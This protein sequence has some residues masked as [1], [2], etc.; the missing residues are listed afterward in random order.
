MTKIK[1][2][3]L[4]I[5]ASVLF[6]TFF[7]SSVHAADFHS[8]TS[9]AAM[10]GF[11][12]CFS[13]GAYK[14]TFKASEGASAF[15][16]NKLGGEM[17]KLPY[18]KTDAE[19]NN[20][21]CKQIVLGFGNKN[22]TL[23]RGLIP[24]S[25][26]NSTDKKTI[27][28][29]FAGSDNA[30]GS[31]TMG[32]TAEGS[33][34][35]D[36]GQKTSQLVV[37]FKDFDCRDSSGNT[38]SKKFKNMANNEEYSKLIFPT[39]TKDKNGHWFFG[40]AAANNSGIN[41]PEPGSG[42]AYNFAFCGDS[43]VVVHD[44]TV[45]KDILY[46]I[47]IF[48]NPDGFQNEEGSAQADG[49]DGWWLYNSNFLKGTIKEGTVQGS[50]EFDDWTLKYSGVGY[51]KGPL[52][53]LNSKNNA[54]VKVSKTEKYDDLAL[55]D[56]EVYDLYTYYVKDVY[57]KPVVC[58]GASNF[59]DYADKPQINWVD[60]KDCRID[61]DKQT[62]PPAYDVYGVDDKNHF[63]AKITLDDIIAKLATLDLS[64]LNTEDPGTAG[65]EPTD[66][67]N[68]DPDCHTK[69]GALGWIL[70]PI[71]DISSNMVEQV[72][73][74]M[75]QPYLS[76]DAALFDT[77]EKG[78]QTV[79]EVWGL[80]QGF[81]NLT[82]VIL[83]L[84]VIFSQLTGVG[85]DNYGIKKILPK[86]IIGA[87]LINMS[88][89]I[90]Q[91][92]VDLSNIL[93]RAIASMFQGVA[94][95]I[96]SDLAEKTVNL[97][98]GH[99]GSVSG[100]FSGVG[101]DHGAGTILLVIV[102]IAGVFGVG[103]FLAAGPA[104]IIP[105]L[106]ALISLV[107][108]IFFLFAL[109]ALRQ[110]IAVILVVVSP[111]AFAMY[112]LPNTK[113]IFDKW[114]QAF[115]GMLIAYPIA[116]ALVFGG[117]LVSKILLVA[118][119]SSEITSLG[120]LL[121]AAVV[122][123]AP[124]FFIPSV[125][126]KSM[127]AISGLGNIASRMQTTAKGKL[128]TPA[129]SYLNRS[130][131]NDYKLRRQEAREAG[132]SDRR[133]RKKGQIAR[134][135]LARLDGRDPDKMS[136]RQRVQ[137]RQAVRDEAAYAK[138]EADL[139]SSYITSLGNDDLSARMAAGLEEG[140]MEKFGSAMDELGGRD[141][142]ALLAQLTTLSE[143]DAWKNM[144]ERKKAAVAAKLRGQKGN[145]FAQA[146]GKLIAQ[147]QA[148]NVSSFNTLAEKGRIQD[149][150][151]EN[152]AT[153]LAS[154]DKDVYKWLNGDPSYKNA[155]GTDTKALARDSFRSD[156]LAEA[157]GQVS[158]AQQAQFAQFIAT[159]G[160]QATDAKAVSDAQLANGGNA[161]I[162][163]AYAGADSDQIK[164]AVDTGQVND[165]TLKGNIQ[166][167]F[168]DQIENINANNE[169]AG[170]TNKGLADAAGIKAGPQQVVIAGIK[171]GFSGGGT[172]GGTGG[173]AGGGTGGGPAPAPGGGGAGGGTGGGPAPAPPRPR[174]RPSPGGGSGSGGRTP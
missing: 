135:R 150:V 172:G 39:V 161:A 117:D 126:R 102:G 37:N 14:G 75:I 66:G 32:Y 131:L 158:G 90:C 148:G 115:K 156:D 116:S 101:D 124:I 169:L 120:L 171:P 149:K 54:G 109:L 34:N 127:N 8:I 100:K 123:V 29:F 21:D 99:A 108:G 79:R 145:P 63:T 52:S 5:F 43:T 70:C 121:S 170:A 25:V 11:Y 53:T 19:D 10:E 7:A 85:I 112:M 27:K 24:D 92:A 98:P 33:G 136:R 107:V 1:K 12:Q 133:M 83:F 146:Y 22:K 62:N 157:M 137:Y 163:A 110:A 51:M 59:D 91:L 111:M 113:K 84:V 20:T 23:N 31:G 125:I 73:T 140:D 18:G 173:G 81:A 138:S 41:V 38:A 105:V 26:K 65:E 35:V 60:G 13:A 48:W 174:P 69:A 58:E 106:L 167:T 162:A 71:I 144:D 2:L 15:V 87:V 142:G 76:I 143:T 88:Y 68:R 128:R 153:N 147:E 130:G 95:G 40:D 61:K 57:Q 77:G 74:G 114:Y 56:Q 166:R 86:L 67:E 17:V 119:G 141:Q 45:G 30:G 89:L 93:G 168:H 9:K 82:F 165:P 64:S 122:G 103:A 55:T 118:D 42:E 6:A 97:Y 16:L 78:G 151:K 28:N 44:G 155:A 104:I 132:A 94:S 129:Q 152:G 4:L 49:D 134:N 72:Y 159:R 3:S 36:E 46:S 154:M 160:Q 139:S 47:S 164:T 80:F 96:N 50:G